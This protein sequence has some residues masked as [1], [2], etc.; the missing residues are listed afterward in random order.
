MGPVWRADRPQ[1]GRFREWYQCDI[2]V[3]GGATSDYEVEIITA[4]ERVLKE[5][6]LGPY[7]FR[8]SDKRLLPLVLEGYGVAK[9]KVGPIMIA[10]DKL[11]KD[12]NQA[13]REIDDVLAPDSEPWKK[14][15]AL[16]LR[17]Y[18]VRP[19]D[20]RRH[21]RMSGLQTYRSS[22]DH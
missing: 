11:D 3:V 19:H 20:T 17:A 13:R 21:E 14:V 9:N 6:N 10:L 2:D 22:T 16:L 15:T 4:T 8:L 5:L 7:R 12:V 1:R 18:A